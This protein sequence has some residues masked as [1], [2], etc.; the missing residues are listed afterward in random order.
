MCDPSV[1]LW[2]QHIRYHTE[3]YEPTVVTTVNSESRN[4]IIMTAEIETINTKPVVVVTFPFEVKHANQCRISG[5]FLE[6]CVEELG[7]VPV[8]EI[9][10]D[11]NTVDVEEVEEQEDV[12]LW[13]NEIRYEYSSEDE[14]EEFT[15]QV[16]YR[17]NFLTFLSKNYSD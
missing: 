4:E 17:D 10:G 1:F 16:G 8:V 12:M 13:K 11:S 15:Q 3:S 9:S 14:Y 2:L 5:E 7:S 6:E